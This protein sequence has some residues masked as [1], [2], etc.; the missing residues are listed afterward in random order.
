[1]LVQSCNQLI[2]HILRDVPCIYIY[3][4]FSKPI[5]WGYTVT[6]RKTLET[7]FA[8]DTPCTYTADQNCHGLGKTK[9]ACVRIYRGYP[10]TDPNRQ[11]KN[12]AGRPKFDKRYKVQKK[13]HTMGVCLRVQWA[14]VRA[15]LLGWRSG[16]K[17]LWLWTCFWYTAGYTVYIYI[18][19]G[20]SFLYCGIYRAYIYIYMCFRH[21]SLDVRVAL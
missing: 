10:V 14:V 8:V 2:V 7:F 17:L 1:M 4:V 6:L 13:T 5:L 19:A 15:W 11:R 12:L 3:M 20:F 21:C 16:S 9:I 18:Y